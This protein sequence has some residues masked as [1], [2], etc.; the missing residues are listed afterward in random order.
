MTGSMWWNKSARDKNIVKYTCDHLLWGVIR[1]QYDFVKV[2][3]TEGITTTT[4]INV[5]VAEDITKTQNKLNFNQ[6]KQTLCYKHRTISL[7]TKPEQLTR[8]NIFH[9]FSS[10]ITCTEIININIFYGSFQLLLY[11]L[12]LDQKHDLVILTLPPRIYRYQHTLFR[13]ALARSATA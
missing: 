6:V 7:Q 5:R 9:V 1:R 8:H 10:Y 3:Q 4:V 13:L 12:R 11:S 2:R